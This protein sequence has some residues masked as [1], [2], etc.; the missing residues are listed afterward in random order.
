M[1]I[2]NIPVTVKGAFSACAAHIQ[3]IWRQYEHLPLLIQQH[4]GYIHLMREKR[5]DVF[6][7]RHTP[8]DA[9]VVQR[10]DIECV[11]MSLCEALD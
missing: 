4:I 5:I 11:G 3:G 10:P 1:Q 9:S 7:T 8:N 6:P 2:P